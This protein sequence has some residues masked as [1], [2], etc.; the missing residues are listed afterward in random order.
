MKAA[1]LEVQGLSNWFTQLVAG[2]CFPLIALI[3]YKG[4]RIV[5]TSL[6][7]VGPNTLKYGSA[8]GGRTITASDEVL[9]QLIERA[10]SSM[11]LKKF[12]VGRSQFPISG[13]CDIEGHLGEDGRYYIV[14]FARTFPPEAPELDAEGN[15]KEPGAMLYKRLRPELVRTNT[16]PLCS[17][18]FTDWDA[19]DENRLQNRQDVIEATERIVKECVPALIAELEAL[20][21]N[22]V[23]DNYFSTWK[24]GKIKPIMK[25][26]TVLNLSPRLHAHGI[27]MRYLGHVRARLKSPSW[28]ILV[29]SMA[30][31][32]LLKDQLR[33]KLRT[34]LRNKTTS[35]AACRL[36]V[37]NFFNNALFR[38]LSRD[39]HCEPPT[40]SDSYK[41]FN[42]RDELEAKYPSILSERDKQKPLPI[43]LNSTICPRV[44]ICGC[45]QMGALHL[46]DA[47]VKGLV[48]TVDFNMVELVEQDIATISAI[49]S[50]SQRLYIYGALSAQSEMLGRHSMLA[51]IVEVVLT[52]MAPEPE[53]QLLAAAGPAAAQH[54]LARLNEIVPMDAIHN[55]L[56]KKKEHVDT[57]IRLAE[58]GLLPDNA[59]HMKY[60][61]DIGDP[62]PKGYYS[63]PKDAD[64]A[65]CRKWAIRRQ[66]AVLLKAGQHLLKK[67]LLAF[68]HDPIATYLLSDILIALA[69]TYDDYHKIDKMFERVYSLLQ[70]SMQYLGCPYKCNLLT[71]TEALLDH[72][73][74][75]INRSPR[76]L[77]AAKKLSDRKS[78]V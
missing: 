20:D 41:L 73:E 63:L 17:S 3:D 49:V 72:A 11:N 36:L 4:F 69:S 19:Y 57:L 42:I 27:N 35:E 51:M 58:A 67:S 14:N 29:N 53:Q 22:A 15:P 9:Y 52:A 40:L 25:M 24:G 75:Y 5:A 61:R 62:E 33:S 38:Q 66:A 34:Q 23:S 37:A 26:V 56:S 1:K 31:A 78:V 70:L 13:P 74:T 46:S 6:L 59:A 77:E 32:R 54:H 43:W 68:S 65:E 60:R 47:T 76:D 28:R 2:L 10:T 7:P 18:A 50:H 55:M 48:K 39:V 44:V 12:N 45:V 8:D 71:F 64:P 30:V 16:V 21:L